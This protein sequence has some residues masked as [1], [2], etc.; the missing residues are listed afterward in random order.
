MT[1]QSAMHQL[2]TP[3][4]AAALLQVSTKTLRRYHDRG[5]AFV[6]PSP[7]TTRYRADD[8]ADFIAKATIT[9]RIAP[10]IRASGT[11][12]SRSQVVDFMALAGR[13]TSRPPKP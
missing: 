3:V 8:I 1:A 2:L 4:E 10:K 13:R 12:T 9:C 7:G 11:S 5:L 6:M